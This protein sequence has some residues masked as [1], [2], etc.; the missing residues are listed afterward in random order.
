MRMNR[1]LRQFTVSDIERKKRKMFA[2]VSPTKMR[3]GRERQ[4]R[5]SFNILLGKVVTAADNVLFKVR[6]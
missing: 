3:V 1:Q 5:P 4:P 2:L 6:W